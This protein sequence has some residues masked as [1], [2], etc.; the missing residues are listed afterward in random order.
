MN[1]YQKLGMKPPTRNVLGDR[2]L[3][4]KAQYTG[5]AVPVRRTDAAQMWRSTDVVHGSPNIKLPY[6]L[7]ADNGLSGLRGF[8]AFGA[9][10]P[11]T[12]L[13]PGVSFMFDI[14]KKDFITGRPI[15]QEGIRKL[16]LSWTPVTPQY[17][18][19]VAKKLQ[20]L[21]AAGSAGE[22]LADTLVG[23]GAA[24]A[25]K[26]GQVGE[27]VEWEAF[28][29]GARGE[30]DIFGKVIRNTVEKNRLDAMKEL[31]AWMA[32]VIG[33]PIP[34]DTASSYTPSTTTPTYTPG[35]LPTGGGT[36][37][38]TTSRNVVTTGSIAKPAGISP[39]TIGVI[40][41][42][43]IVGLLVARKMMKG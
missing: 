32:Y 16:G 37:S 8:G 38:V 22:T 20:D 19:S 34:Q 2:L 30:V 39:V 42:V 4:S 26:V 6:P 41:V 17:V 15:H 7:G 27:A 29:L 18:Q 10:D 13:V 31:K 5:V 21:R 40:G 11:A 25:K 28:G 23:D 3:G 1:L 24:L 14:D 35:S 36:T 12:E 9:G 43:G 33:V